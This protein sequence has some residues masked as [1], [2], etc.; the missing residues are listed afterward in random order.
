MKLTSIDLYSNNQQVAS[1][2]FRDPRATNPYIAQSTTGLDADEIV[3]KYYGRSGST[4]NGFHNLALLKREIVLLVSLNPQFS[5]GKTYSDL[6]DNLYRAI[7][8]SRDGTVQLR[9]MNGKNPLAA[10]TGFITKFETNLQSKTPQVQMTISCDDGILR[11]IEEVNLYVNQLGTDTTL[12]DH[13]S[14]SPHGFKF[15]LTLDAPTSAFTMQ[16]D[17][18]PGPAAWK[19]DVLYNFLAD[20]VIHYSSVVGE[21]DFYITRGLVRIDLVDKILAGSQWPIMY[22]GGTDLQFISD[23]PFTWNEFTYYHTYWGV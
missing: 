19:F 4:G 16:P 18:A 1:L 9:F 2:S 5:A 7:S 12:V 21:K 10:I 11:S 3:P 14:T 15:S 6:R 23:G 22:P 13:V 8:S 20:D 17:S